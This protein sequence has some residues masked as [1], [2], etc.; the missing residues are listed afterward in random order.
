MAITNWMA[1]P[2]TRRTDDPANVVGHRWLLCASQQKCKTS[3]VA[4]RCTLTWEVAFEIRDV[5]GPTSK[6]EPV[7]GKRSVRRV[8]ACAPH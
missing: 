2:P 4:I 3:Q 5:L 6:T 1:R 8:G 7:H